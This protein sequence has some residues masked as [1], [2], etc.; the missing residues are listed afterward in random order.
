[1]KNWRIFLTLTILLMASLLPLSD[2][3]TDAY[4]E[5]KLLGGD[6]SKDIVFPSGGGEDGSNAF[7][8][9]NA[10][11]V[12]DANF[13]VT[14]QSASNGEYPS[15]VMIDVGNDG[16]AE[17]GFFGDG[18]GA[19]GHQ[20]FFSDN[21]TQL[22]INF[23]GP[24]MNNSN[25]VILPKNAVVTNAFVNLT[26]YGGGQGGVATPYLNRTSFNTA[27]T[28]V[29]M[30]TQAN[31]ETHPLGAL[32]SN[33]YAG[34]G[35]SS[36]TTT[37]G[38]VQNTAGPAQGN[39]AGAIPGEGLHPVS[40]CLSGIS[41]TSTFTMSFNLPVGGAG[42][43]VVD[44][45]TGGGM[46]FKAYD[47]PSGTGTLLATATAPTSNYQMNNMVFLG[48]VDGSHSISSVVWFIPNNGGDVVAIDDIRFGA[49]G[50][51]PE[52]CSLDI[53]NDGIIEWNMTGSLEQSITV[54]DFT[55][56]LNSILTS[57][58]VAFTDSFGNQM[59]EV[60]IKVA[61]T[62]SGFL[63]V[64]K[65]S[66]K[67]S[68]TA[69]ADTNSHS[70][71]LS[72]ELN[73]HI[74]HIGEG[75]I[76]IPI[77]VSSET[78]GIVSISNF[79]ILYD[80]F[81][82]WRNLPGSIMASEDAIGA[83]I[84]DFKPYITDDSNLPEDL[85]IAIKSVSNEVMTLNITE[86]NTLIVED[87]TPEHWNSEENELI[88]I[89]FFLSDTSDQT[90]ESSLVSIMVVAVDDEPIVNSE[91]ALDDRVIPEGTSDTSID[92]DDQSYFYDVEHDILHYEVA[93]DPLETLTAEQKNISVELDPNS[94]VIEI[95]ALGDFNT[96]D[97]PPIPVWIFCDD[98]DDPSEGGI[99][100]T[101]NGEGNYVHREFLVEVSPVNDEPYWTQ[102]VPVIE[103]LEDT[104]PDVLELKDHS[105]DVDTTYDD[106]TFTVVKQPETNHLKVSLKGSNLSVEVDPDYYG[107]GALT[108][109]VE[110]DEG[111]SAVQDFQIV[112]T[113]VNDPPTIGITS[114]QNNSL[115]LG[116]VAIR[117]SASDIDNTKFQVRL[118]IDEGNWYNLSGQTN[119]VHQ[120]DTT[121]VEN[122]VHTIEAVATD[123]EL[124][125]EIRS[126]VLE[127][128]NHI[129][130]PPLVFFTNPTN[131]S[132]VSGIINVTGT[133]IDPENLE[134]QVNIS[135]SEPDMWIPITP[136]PDTGFWTYQV[137]T[138]LFSDGNMTIWARAFD[139]ELPSLDVNITIIIK[140]QLDDITPIDGD[141][142]DSDKG[143]KDSSN[144]LWLIILVIIIVLVVLIVLLYYRKKQKEE[145]R[146]R[147]E[148]ARAASTPPPTPVLRLA[149]PT[150]PSVQQGPY[151]QVAPLTA[152]Y[153]V[154]TQSVTPEYP[155]YGPGAY[156]G[157]A[158]TGAARAAQMTIPDQSGQY[159]PPP[160]LHGPDAQLQLPPSADAA[161]QPVAPPPGIVATPPDTVA[162]QPE[163]VP[164]QPGTVPAQP[165]TVA[166][167]N[168]GSP[169]PIPAGGMLTCPSCGAQGQL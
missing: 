76:T 12:S 88:F 14:S 101:A 167:F 123:G 166:C 34:I 132:V 89:D 40:R 111:E 66:I 51:G 59:V 157:Y 130:E 126:I 98:D 155:S 165:G 45:F 53:G 10:V 7:E 20:T 65:L 109:E 48:I 18:Y 42:L 4:I 92:L 115:V 94:L 108:V 24:G 63:R 105:G 28:G 8:L 129:N 22:N 110:D 82:R 32:V 15:E 124:F 52:N 68:Y 102:P 152:G 67:Y 64:D 13:N 47:G 5:T 153:A 75:N 127:V 35:I 161:I 163:T 91:I 114:P 70:G 128:A 71:N 99:N 100:T 168:C 11:Y 141:G 50:S 30:N 31:F 39:T 3:D 29:L 54:P 46:T 133:A 83:E 154:A 145:E 17:W 16:D 33:H 25:S 19:L 107:S 43:M 73:Q 117:G 113:A 26:G 61:G 120:W 80:Q 86:N 138:T 146:K 77:V 81:P 131:G 135:F 27:M 74:P 142:G 36:M 72:N 21:T 6:T 87:I 49:G 103:C 164:A 116:V 62:S 137:D 118:R 162:A 139:G 95:E 121:S 144:L 160:P 140:N 150:Q 84:L 37:S 38:T 156:G 134:V 147:E 60:P 9:P 93:I 158:T 55:T 151:A 122:G 96:D 44:K 2:M 90:V 104:N 85:R 1:M 79:H 97:G 125:S 148:E 106:M 57:A 119:W 56:Q 136:D 41:P 149:A 112:V 143:G 78:G 69:K 169:V 23:P 58:P 159:A